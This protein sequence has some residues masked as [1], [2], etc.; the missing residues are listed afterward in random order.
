[1]IRGAYALSLLVED[2]EMFNKRFPTIAGRKIGQVLKIILLNMLVREFVE[3][4]Y[5]SMAAGGFSLG[6][7]IPNGRYLI[8]YVFDDSYKIVFCREIMA[9]Y[10][11]RDFQKKTK[12]V[13]TDVLRVI[14]RVDR[15]FKGVLVKEV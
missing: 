7:R 5:V 8:I 11:C 15:M 10:P 3:P 13:I 6:W 2:E 4:A 14:G 1:M 12:D 9:P